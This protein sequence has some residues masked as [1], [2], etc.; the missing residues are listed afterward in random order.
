[1]EDIPDVTAAEDARTN[2]MAIPSSI[3]MAGKSFDVE[4]S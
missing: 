4:A 2:R 1:M 3:R